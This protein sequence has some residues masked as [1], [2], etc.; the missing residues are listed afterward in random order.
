MRYVENDGIAPA[1]PQGYVTTTAK[2]GQRAGVLCLDS[3]FQVL[4]MHLV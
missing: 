4:L 1:R 2:P 3:A